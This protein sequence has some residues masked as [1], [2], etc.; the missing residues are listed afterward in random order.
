MSSGLP[1]LIN[2]FSTCLSPGIPSRSLK[3]FS[4]LLLA[5]FGVS[6][7]LGWREAKIRGR[8]DKEDRMK[9]NRTRRVSMAQYNYMLS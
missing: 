4:L 3:N 5:G 9:R 6:S 8:G 1:P 2:P 7:V